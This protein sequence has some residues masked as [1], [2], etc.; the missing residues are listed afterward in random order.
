MELPGEDSLETRSVPRSDR[1]RQVLNAV[2][3]G[4]DEGRFTG[5]SAGL[6]E[7]T[8]NVTQWSADK[9]TTACV[10]VL[11]PAWV[12][13]FP[14]RPPTFP[15]VHIKASLSLAVFQGAPA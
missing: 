3:Q 11:C 4:C 1:Q 15:G 13:V 2:M 7:A 8:A 10:R 12:H 14:R 9:L 5:Q 6:A